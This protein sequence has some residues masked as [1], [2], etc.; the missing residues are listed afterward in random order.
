[1]KRG[2]KKGFKLSQ[3]TK[4][5]I[6]LCNKGKKLSNEVKEKIRLAHLGKINKN[7]KYRAIHAWIIKYKGRPKI[8]VDCGTTSNEHK[9]EWS[10]INHKYH[11]I[12]DDY[13]ARCLRCHYFYDVKN[14]K[15]PYGKNQYTHP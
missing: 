10:N 15:R 9:L 2:R 5:K 1:M 12:L 8:C 6:G 7:A 11:R 3:E 13:Q 4:I 14:N